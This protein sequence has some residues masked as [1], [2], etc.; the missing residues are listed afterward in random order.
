M[1]APIET[2]QTISRRYQLR[3]TVRSTHTSDGAI[4]LEIGRGK[5][6]QLNSVGSRILQLFQSKPEWA[7]ADLG[8]EVSR[9]F[10]IPQDRAVADIGEFVELLAQHQLIVPVS[11]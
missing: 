4:V 1:K 2:S 9:E 8:E 3:E 10:C 5:L 11:P 6:F 7:V